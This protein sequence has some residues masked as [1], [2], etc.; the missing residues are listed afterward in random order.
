MN[1]L[2]TGDVGTVR[3]PAAS[4]ITKVRCVVTGTS[5]PSVADVNLNIRADAT[6]TTAGGT[7][8]T[9]TPYVCNTTTPV[10]DRTINNA[11]LTAG[12]WLYVTYGVVT[13]AVNMILTVD[14]T[15]P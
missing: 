14:Y 11:A 12:Q 6:P 5:S 15:T 2:A 10:V 4:T 9:T 7:N 3:I 1:G 13:G 8:V